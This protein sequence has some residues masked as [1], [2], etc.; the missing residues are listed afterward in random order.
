MYVS[1]I[2][3]IWKC[4]CVLIKVIYDQTYASPYYLFPLHVYKRELVNESLGK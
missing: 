1:L 2:E 4:T 3:S